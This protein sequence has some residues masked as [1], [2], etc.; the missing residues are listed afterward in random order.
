[1]IVG[2]ITWM[3]I[4]AGFASVM[5]PQT[6]MVPH[7]RELTNALSKHLQERIVQDAAAFIGVEAEFP[8]G[9]VLK[10]RPGLSD[11]EIQEVARAYAAEAEKIR[12]RTLMELVLLAGVV[13]TVPCISAALLGLGIAWVR[14]GF[15]H[16]RKA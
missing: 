12:T 8:N 10:L 11:E 1:L 14:R 6:E 2:S 13:A 7:S 16:T 5:I 9:H 4:V 3:V 15:K